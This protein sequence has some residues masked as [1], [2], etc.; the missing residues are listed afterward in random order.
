MDINEIK[1]NFANN[2]IKLRK[3][4]GWNQSQMGDY[5]HYSFKAIS[6]WENGDCIPDI[7]V[8]TD[9]AEKFNL[10]V[11]ELIS[12]KNVVALSNTV[13]NRIFI[14]SCSCVFPYLVGLIVFLVLLSTKVPKSYIAF[15]AAGV[16]SGAVLVVLA[17]IWFSKPVIFIGASFMPIAAA[18]LFMV[19]FDFKYFWIFIILA[20]VTI[21]VLIL[22]FLIDIPSQRKNLKR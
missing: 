20:I 18:L 19:I 13:K 9:I 7:D 5:I 12:E 22:F 14:T 3:S 10:T 2:I 8:L 6:K 4:K 15:P 1:R 17:R 16:A 21:L 11:D